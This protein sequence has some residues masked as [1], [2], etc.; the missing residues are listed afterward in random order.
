MKRFTLFLDD[1]LYAMIR[2]ESKD[3]ALSLADI[4]R[5]RLRLG[6]TVEVSHTVVDRDYEEYEVE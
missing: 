1:E 4:V 5:K 6:Y 2:Q 3:E